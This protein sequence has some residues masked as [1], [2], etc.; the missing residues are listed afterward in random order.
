MSNQKWLICSIC[1]QHRHLDKCPG[2][3]KITEIYP[4]KENRTHSERNTK[5]LQNGCHPQRHKVSKY[6]QTEDINEIISEVLNVFK[7]KKFKKD[8]TTNTDKKLVVSKTFHLSIN[9][10]CDYPQTIK[11]S[12]IPQMKTELKQRHVKHRD[13]IAEV[14]R[15]FAN[16]NLN[17]PTVRNGPRILPVVKTDRSDKASVFVCCHYQC[18]NYL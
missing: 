12:S 7:S 10:V 4:K 14:N 6:V 13:P 17:R 1:L 5:N 8:A 15:M 2:I 11:S 16:V 3:D 18:E 9:S